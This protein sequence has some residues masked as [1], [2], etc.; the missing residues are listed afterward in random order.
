MHD[1]ARRRCLRRAMSHY[2]ALCHIMSYYVAGTRRISQGFS[3]SV[4]AMQGTGLFFDA[5]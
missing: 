3:G 4:L 5:C 2:V 1:G